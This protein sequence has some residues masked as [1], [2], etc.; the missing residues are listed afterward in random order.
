MAEQHIT[1]TITYIADGRANPEAG[2][3]T[4]LEAQ[5]ATRGKQSFT[6]WDICKI[7]GFSFPV[8]QMRFVNNA[9]YCIKYKHYLDASG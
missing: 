5:F 3:T 7:C 1:R 8:S 2:S 9:P 6:K 4:M